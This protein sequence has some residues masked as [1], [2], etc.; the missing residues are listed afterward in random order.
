MSYLLREGGE[1]TTTPIRE[2]HAPLFNLTL[3]LCCTNSPNALPVLQPEGLDLP[4]LLEA[5]DLTDDWG[6][7]KAQHKL[8]FIVHRILE[9]THR[10]ARNEQPGFFVPLS[11]KV[12]RQ[13]LHA[14]YALPAIE[15]L[16]KIGVI[17]RNPRYSSGRFSKSYRLTPTYNTR[18][19]T[20]RLIRDACLAN[21]VRR[22][23]DA[24]NAEALGAD[25][26]RAFILANLAHVSV[27]HEASV[28]VEA[29]R[30]PSQAVAAAWLLSLH[31]LAQQRY[32]LRADN[33]SGRIFHNL[34]QCP[35]ALRRFLR[36]GGTPTSE[37]D[38][39]NAQ[40]FFLLSLYPK[41]HKERTDFAAIVGQGRFY[42]HLFLAMDREKRKAWGTDLQSWT[43]RGSTHRD[44]FKKHAL[45][46]VLYSVPRFHSVEPV[47]V[48]FGRL[49]PWLAGELTLRCYN[50][51]GTSALAREMQ[52]REAE[53][54]LGRVVPRIQKELRECRAI[55]IHDGLLCETRFAP[56]IARL[57]IEETEA[58]YGVT[59]LVKIA[60]AG[61][62]SKVA[63]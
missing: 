38:L 59:P 12:L 8:A 35:R 17:E 27:S 33:K 43:E 2:E 18:T 9:W 39:A 46:H 41:D 49:F 3:P 4:G 48:T 29:R 26:T 19:L 50:K 42:E 58:T 32:W 24:R 11:A 37:V 25:T 63:A 51:A 6:T 45:R 60:R 47:C 14:R 54:I 21:K 55:S 52:K 61:E 20:L 30:Y 5:H 16:I 34:T 44:R 15:C 23:D 40:P 53:L 36:I 57:M 10:D 7:K 31:D 28:I 22:S 62:C 56:D 1:A 13:F